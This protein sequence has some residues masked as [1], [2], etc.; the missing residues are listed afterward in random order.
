MDG[1]GWDGMGWDGMGW[2]GMGWDGMGWD[3]MGWD[4]WMDGWMDGQKIE[5]FIYPRWLCQNYNITTLQVS[6][7]SVLHNIN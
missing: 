2:D 3:G 7:I 6:L 1:M 4:G 5:N